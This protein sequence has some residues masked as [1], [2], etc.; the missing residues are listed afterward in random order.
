MLLQNEI[1]DLNN[2]KTT[3]EKRVADL[4]AKSEKVVQLEIEKKRY[5]EREAHFTEATEKI[6]QRLE[7][8]EKKVKFFEE[9]NMRLRQ[10]SAAQDQQ[11]AKNRGT[12]AKTPHS[13][14]YY[15]VESSL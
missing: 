2:I 8:A 4:Q 1:K 3:L 10:N 11:T 9:E 5:M 6:R 12:T 7:D 13:N 15:F 14:L